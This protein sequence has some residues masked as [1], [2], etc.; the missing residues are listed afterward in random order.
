ML[1]GGFS[2]HWR[3][4]SSLQ[5]PVELLVKY[6]IQSYWLDLFAHHAA[7]W[8]PQHPHGSC[9]CVVCVWPPSLRELATNSLPQGIATPSLGLLHFK[10]NPPSAFCPLQETTTLPLTLPPNKKKK[11]K[12]KE[13]IPCNG[14]YKHACILHQEEEGALLFCPLQEL[15]VVVQV[16]GNV[17]KQWGVFM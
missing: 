17:P 1:Q 9:C 6:G 15:P 14:V 13:K 11:K 4:C 16:H 10:P 5:H 8:G 7:Q 3:K 2:L 12:K